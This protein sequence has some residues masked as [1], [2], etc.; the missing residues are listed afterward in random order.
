[1]SGRSLV[2][3][4]RAML[5]AFAAQAQGMLERDRLARA[6]AQA[7]RLEATERLRDALLAAVGHDLRTP[8]ASARAA[9]NSL[10]A[11]DVHWSEAERQE[12]LATAEE[13]LARLTTLVADLLDLSRLR[14]GV[15]AVIVE[16]V[17]LDDLLPPALDE[18]GASAGRVA[19]RVPDDVPPAL[20]D[21]ALL[22][23]ALVNVIGNALRHAPQGA[24]TVTVSSGAD[25]VEV[26]VIDHG[27]GVPEPDKERLFV[28]FQR[29]GDTDNTTGLGLGLAL[30]RGL[31][32]AMQGTLEAEDTPGG[33]LTM[34]LS[35]PAAPGGATGAVE[36]GRRE[37]TEDVG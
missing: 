14:A 29:L 16:P 7:T 10:Q 34:V 26:R 19:L 4:D 11:A 9:V 3:A 5:G 1:M 28:P 21:A 37:R 27:A 25:R 6:A 23:R 24:P 2:A 30:S 35:L 22:T 18:L 8:L 15:L 13:S 36:P 20:A 12:L 32:E 31:V 17:W 33:G